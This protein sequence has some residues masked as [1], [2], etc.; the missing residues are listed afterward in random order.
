VLQHDVERELAFGIAENRAD[1]GVVVVM[2]PWTGE[3]LAMASEPDFNPNVYG[4]VDNKI[5]QNRAV[6]EIYEPG[7]TFKTVTASAALDEGVLTPETLIDCAPGY[8]DIGPRRVHD[9]H[10]NGTLT[11]TDVIVKSSNVGAIRTG[12][13]VGPE[14]LERFVR[15]FGFGTRMLQELPAESAGKVWS[16]LSDTA[17]AS[18]SMGYQVGVTPLQMVTALSSIANGGMLMRPH[19]VRAVI[20]DGVRHPVAPEALR[21]TIKA[22]T[23]AE[24]TT[25]MEGVVERG[26]GKPARID[27]YTIAGKT[28]TAAKLINGEYSKQ[29]YFSSFIGFMP[30]RK[31]AIAV[32]VMVDAPS[33]GP[34]FGGLVAAP[35][36]KRIGEIAVR[37][38]GIPR[39][40]DPETPVVMA[41][42]ITP[43]PARPVTYVSPS[44]PAA[45]GGRDGVMPDL[46]GLSARAAVRTLARLGLVPRLKGSGFVVEQHPAA[47]APIDT[48]SPVALQLERQPP[49]PPADSDIAQP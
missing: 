47:G 31:P 6:E 21:R 30:S 37:H 4:T 46:R 8:I 5:R 32:L 44:S 20:R 28:G 49:P 48:A 42:N 39:S 29:K 35:I 11:F 18:V 13:K 7:S 45:D 43:S 26:T 15:R 40:I 2:D 23:A 41:R 25:I 17:L 9:V 27:G 1:G 3:I 34:Y 12:F 10:P 24:L 19:L 36:F 38:L 16:K 33:A 22:D 14:R